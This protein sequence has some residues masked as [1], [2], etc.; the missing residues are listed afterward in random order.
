MVNKITVTRFKEITEEV[1]RS[2]S[3][4]WCG[5]EFNETDAINSFSIHFGYG[6]KYDGDIYYFDI[7]D[8]CFDK[9]LKDKASEVI[10]QRDEYWGE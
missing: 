7:C 6:S 10:E 8:D 4:D 3:C 9:Y 5:E 2:V 1:I